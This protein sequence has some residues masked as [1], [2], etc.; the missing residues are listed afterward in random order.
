MHACSREQRSSVYEDKIRTMME[1]GQTRLIVDLADMREAD[2]ELCQKVR[3]ARNASDMHS[4][5][6][7]APE[8]K[9]QSL[10]KLHMHIF[11]AELSS[12]HVELFPCFTGV[13]IASGPDDNVVLPF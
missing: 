10:R 1:K 2:S 6:E 8:S 3:N 12:Y 5:P 11:C 9:K 13:L 4:M 7:R